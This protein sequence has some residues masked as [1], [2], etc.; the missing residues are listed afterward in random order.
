MKLDK[1]ATNYIIGVAIVTALIFGGAG[2]YAGAK[3]SSTTAAQQ[4]QQA[5]RGGAQFRGSQNGGMTSGNV[6]SLQ[7]SM[8]TVGTRD[9]ASKVVI[10]TGSTK[11]LKSVTGTKSDV[12]VGGTV[13]ITGTA[14]GDGSITADTVQ[15]RQSGSQPGGR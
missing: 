6:I 8:M 2:Y 4:G 15:L 11:V 13:L 14:N 10:I 3:K 12:V 5:F 9:G 7:D 1:H